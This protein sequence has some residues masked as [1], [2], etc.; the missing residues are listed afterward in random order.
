MD[1]VK[2]FFR[3]YWVTILIFILMFGV[4]FFVSENNLINPFLFPQVGKIARNFDAELIVKNLLSSLSLLLPSLFI[5]TLIALILGIIVGLNK[6][7]RTTISPVINAISVIPSVILT[8]FA[9]QL[10]PGFRITATFI[11]VYNIIWPTYFAT[12]NGILTIEQSYLDIAD[13]LE[14]SGFKR[15]W[16]VLLPGAM[17]SILS[18]FITSL[19][20]SFLVLVISEMYGFTHGLGYYVQNSAILGLFDKVWAGFI[21]LVIVLVIVVHIFDRIKEYLLRWTID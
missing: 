18:G 1:R 16:K 14:I 12:V 11:I 2:D 19:R 21:V 10:L 6:K 5:G 17:P 7:V 9:L 3:T 4:Y 13:S 8:P 15:I 20:S